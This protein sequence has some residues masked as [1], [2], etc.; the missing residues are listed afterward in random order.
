M[1]IATSV[2]NQVFV[3][4]FYRTNAGL[5]FLVIAFAGGFMRS[6]DHLALGEILVST[7]LLSLIPLSVWIMYCLF[8]NNFNRETRYAAAN[9]G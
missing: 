4:Q 2:L 7:P 5:F 6:Q 3:A 9:V 8:V 1:S